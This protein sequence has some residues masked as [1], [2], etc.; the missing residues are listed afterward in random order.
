MESTGSEATL[1]IPFPPRP[2]PPSEFYHPTR[3]VGR[4]RTSFSPD[5]DGLQVTF[6]SN[7]LARAGIIRD[8]FLCHLGEHANLHTETPHRWHPGLGSHVLG[9]VDLA[10]APQCVALVDK[11]G[12]KGGRA[13]TTA[14]CAP[15]LP[16]SQHIHVATLNLHN[17]LPSSILPH[18]GRYVEQEVFV[19]LDPT[20]QRPMMS[21]CPRRPTSG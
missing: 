1:L 10:W 11:R 18:I 6:A 16:R 8:D 17:Q 21:T 13:P 14:D 3:P 15:R 7:R 20:T 9:H 5:L 19:T 4:G 12:N 2:V